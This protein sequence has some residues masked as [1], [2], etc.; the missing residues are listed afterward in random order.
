M[1]RGSTSNGHQVQQSTDEEGNTGG[2]QSTNDVRRTRY[3]RLTNDIRRAGVQS[4]ND[5]VRRT[6]RSN[7]ASMTY[8]LEPR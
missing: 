7:E 5:D 3:Q 1:Q 2:Q 6:V 8:G 4:S